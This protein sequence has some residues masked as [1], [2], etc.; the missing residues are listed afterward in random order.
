[1]ETSKER[2]DRL[3][4]TSFILMEGTK[5]INCGLSTPVVGKP[6]KL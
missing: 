5:G 3:E 2:Y 6:G 4:Q 1:M